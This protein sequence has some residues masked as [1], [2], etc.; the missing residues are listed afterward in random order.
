MTVDRP[1][2]GKAK[3]TY[4]CQ[5]CGFTAAKWL[6][7]CPDCGAWNSL[8]EQAVKPVERNHGGSWVSDVKPVALTYD[9]GATDVRI[10]TGIGELDRTLGGGLVPGSVVLIGGDPGIGKSTLM[11]QACHRLSR[12]GSPVLYVSGEESFDQIRMRARRLGTMTDGLMIFAETHVDAIA[13]EIERGEYKS[14]VVDSIQSTYT[15]R[16]PGTPGSIGQVRE[17]ATELSRIAKHLNVPLF[18]VG[19]VTKEGALAGPRVLEHMVDTVL[20]FEGDEH[21]HLRILRA[22]KNR[23]GSTNEIG[24]FEMT[25][26]GLDEVPNPSRAFLDERPRGTSGSVAAPI[27]QGTRP[28]LVELQALVSRSVLA[29]PR[30]T[31]TGVNANRVNL[32]LAVLEKRAGLNLSDKDVFVNVAGGVRVDEPAADLAVALAIA[33]SFREVPVE[34]D[35][36]A[37]GE[38]GLA[39]EVRSVAHAAKRVT[40]AD[41]LGFKKC[42]L[43]KGSAL[44]EPLNGIETLLVS[45]VR[46]A[47]EL[48]IGR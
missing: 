26:H 23:F 1:A 31:V 29:L 6:G 33:S 11:L 2:Q 22:V 44:K 28:L 35:L 41:K 46:D 8:V 39:G 20:Y 3:V 43:P 15:S 10:A 27:M 19:H 36:T 30:R 5:E 34:P 9:A 37:F 4:A 24:V 42:V 17:C 21:Q 32:I 25:D 40:E 13:G 38:I 47:L 14:V 18:L 45:R 7:K 48:A 12:D 16:L